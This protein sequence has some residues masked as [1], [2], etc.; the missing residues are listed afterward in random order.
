M[1][2]PAAGPTANAAVSATPLAVSHT[3]STPS[4]RARQI[5]LATS[6]NAILP[7]RYCSPR[8]RMSFYVVDTARRIIGCHLTRQMTVQNTRLGSMTRR[9]IGL[10]RYIAR[11]QCPYRVAGNASALRAEKRAPG[12]MPIQS[13]GQSVT[14]RRGR[15]AIYRNRPISSGPYR[16]CRRWRRWRRRRGD[17]RGARRR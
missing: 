4:P 5:L 9:A 8:H 1:Y 14:A 10:F 12:R 13:C 15:E 7:G 11:V 3:R 6:Q 17:W 16:Q 2:A